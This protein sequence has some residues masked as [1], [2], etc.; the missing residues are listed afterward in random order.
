MRKLPMNSLSIA[1][2]PMVR[3][4]PR[5]GGVKHI[6][7]LQGS[8]T[9]TGT[10]KCYDCRKPFTVKIGTI[11]EHSKVPMHKWLQA[12]V[13]CRGGEHHINAYQVS[14]VLGVTFNTAKTMLALIRR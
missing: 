3:F 10:Y 9:R 1:F 2:G 7:R 12:M 6:G 14:N 5:C 13:L 11:F 4:C 8:S